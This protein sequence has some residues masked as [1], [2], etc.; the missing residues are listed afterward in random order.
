MNIARLNLAHCTHEFAAQVIKNLRQVQAKVASRSDVA[1]WID[2]NGPK[3]RYLSRPRYL[4]VLTLSYA[5]RTGKLANGP[6]H[7]KKGDDFFFVNDLNIV[8]DATKVR[9]H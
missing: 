3:V 8:G 9:C 4:R 5:F 6:I 7:L 2:V 1:I